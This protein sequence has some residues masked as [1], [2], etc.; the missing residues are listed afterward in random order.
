MINI[1]RMEN[2]FENFLNYCQMRLRG[3][4][5]KNLAIFCHFRKVRESKKTKRGV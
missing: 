3:E 4:N 1:P 5:E 2:E